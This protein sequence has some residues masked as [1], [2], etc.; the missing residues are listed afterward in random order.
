[1]IRN[2]EE[3]EINVKEHGKSI[4]KSKGKKKKVIEEFDGFLGFKV[5]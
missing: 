3:L 5:R 2:I 4:F 1:M